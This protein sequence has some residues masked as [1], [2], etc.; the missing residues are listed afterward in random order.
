MNWVLI[1]TLLSIARITCVKF[2][3]LTLWLILWSLEGER[4]LQKGTKGLVT[5]GKKQQGHQL[6]QQGVFG[7]TFREKC[8]CF[9]YT[10]PDRGAATLVLMRQE[11]ILPGTM[12]MSDLWAA[13]RGIQAMVYSL[14]SVKH[15]Y[16]LLTPS[17]SPRTNHG[18]FMK[19]RET[20]K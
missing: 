20:Q 15:T 19:K 1:K 16:E 11:C 8:E 18:E 5:R 14:L 9:L 7:G 2:V 3:L 13:Y 17:R 10:V 4:L 6:P 12:I